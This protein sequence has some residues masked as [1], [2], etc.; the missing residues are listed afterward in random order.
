MLTFAHTVE[1][2]LPLLDV[3][4]ATILDIPHNLPKVVQN[5]A[6]LSILKKKRKKKALNK[7]KVAYKA[8]DDA[9]P[10]WVYALVFGI[11]LAVIIAILFH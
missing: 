5:V 2:Y 8:Y 3:L 9:L 10:K 11:V 1:E 6:T 7:K 4:R